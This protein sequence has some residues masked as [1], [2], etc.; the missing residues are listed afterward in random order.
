L[1]VCAGLGWLGYLVPAAKPL[2]VP[3]MILGV[4]AE[5]LLMFRLLVSGV[6]VRRWN[7]RAARNRLQQQGGGSAG[8]APGRS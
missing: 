4:L 7:E 8:H 2:S 5:G 3:I 6:D 1:L